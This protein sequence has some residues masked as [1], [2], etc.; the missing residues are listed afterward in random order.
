MSVKPVTIN[1]IVSNPGIY[2]YKNEMDLLDLILEAGGLLDHVYRYRVEIARI[3]PLNE[4]LNDYAKIITLDLNNDFSVVSNEVDLQKITSFKL[5]P[6]DLVSIRPDPL[7]QY[8]KTVRITGEVMFPGS[9]TII[10]SNEKITDI[11]NRAGGLLPTA[12]PKASKYIRRGSSVNMAFDKIIKNNKSS[13]NFNVQDGDEIIIVPRPNVVTVEGEVNNPGLYK[14]EKGKRL[15]YYIAL[16]GGMNLDAEKEN[17]WIEYP[18]GDS[19]KYN[20]FAILSPKIL[21]G[22]RIIIGLKKEEEPFDHTEYAKE[23][24]TIIANLAQALAVVALAGR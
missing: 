21:D 15:K 22:S 3:D 10:N 17:I 18:N 7:F 16:A 1:G 14:F 19:K 4:E 23:L 20:R 8:Q 2:D 11:L 9:Y 6:Y 5:E 12:Y 13:L 24:T